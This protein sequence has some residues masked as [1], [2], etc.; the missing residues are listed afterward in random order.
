MKRTLIAA[1]AL[2]VGLLA[3]ATTADALYIR[4][5]L[6]VHTD[7]SEADVGD[8]LPFNVTATDEEGATAWSGKTVTVR[9]SYDPN[10]GSENPPAEDEPYPE[11]VSGTLLESLA[12]DE[13]ATATFTWTVP[14]EVDNK[15]VAIRLE[16]ETGELLAIQHIAIG[17]AVPMMMIAMTGPGGE[18]PE[19]TNSETDTPANP[20][21]VQNDDTPTEKTDTAKPRSVP[22]I[23]VL[24]LVGAIG[25]LALVANRR[26]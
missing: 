9:W 5:P 19:Q 12:L 13:K 21:G 20:D 23:G 16:D 17:D 6:Q 24:A 8:T 11:P 14:A 15:N 2:L 26:R 22:S 7:N 10:E 1:T 18:L 25:L 3:T 4:T